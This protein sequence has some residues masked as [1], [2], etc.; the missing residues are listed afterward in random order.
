MIAKHFD[1]VYFK[2]GGSTDLLNGILQLIEKSTKTRRGGPISTFLAQVRGL[3]IK[4]NIKHGFYIFKLHETGY[5]P[6]RESL[7]KDQ[8]PLISLLELDMSY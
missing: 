8:V 7:G 4:Y 3:Y 2:G 1:P 5:S 6:G